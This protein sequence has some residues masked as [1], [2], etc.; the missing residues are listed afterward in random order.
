MITGKLSGLPS[1]IQIP[2]PGHPTLQLRTLKDVIDSGE[3]KKLDPGREK[4]ILEDAMK[5]VDPETKERLRSILLQLEVTE[6]KMQEEESKIKP[7]TAKPNARRSVETPRMTEEKKE[8]DPRP[9]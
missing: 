8:E 7:R 2:I 6:S 5:H 9:S 1:L 4:A 3:C